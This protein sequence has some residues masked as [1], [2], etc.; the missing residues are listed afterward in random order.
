MSQTS[1]SLNFISNLQ[2][3][4]DCITQTLFTLANKQIN[5]IKQLSSFF[6]LAFSSY[7]SFYPFLF[8]L[9]LRHIVLVQNE[10]TS[11]EWTL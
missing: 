2:M 6:L 10:A 5:H 1:I 8:L 3:P 9:I 11:Q 4:T 7:L